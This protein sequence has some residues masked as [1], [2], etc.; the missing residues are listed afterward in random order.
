MPRL[1]TGRVRASVQVG[2]SVLY[3]SMICN[4]MLRW[5][6]CPIECLEQHKINTY[7][8]VRLGNVYDACICRRLF[9]ASDNSHFCCTCEIA[10]RDPSALSTR[11]FRV[12][13][14]CLLLCDMLKIQWCSENVRT[15][16]RARLKWYKKRQ[17]TNL[18]Y[19]VHFHG[20][21][22]LQFPCMFCFMTSNGRLA[23]SL[24]LL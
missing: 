24:M 2:V 23:Q 12:R 4:E 22:G 17:G 18:I 10:H 1:I 3:R 13:T 21:R 8:R 7:V 16:A 20:G 6:Y 9:C 11:A 15:S 14:D 5:V 19:F